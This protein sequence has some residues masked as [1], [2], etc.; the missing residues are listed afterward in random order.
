MRRPVRVAVIAPSITA[1]PGSVDETVN[2]PAPFVIVHV[3]D[4]MFD[5]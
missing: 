3:Q 2:E 5:A 1:A 4:N